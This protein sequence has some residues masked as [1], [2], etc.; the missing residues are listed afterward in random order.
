MSRPACFLL[1]SPQLV[2]IVLTI[3]FGSEAASDVWVLHSLWRLLTREHPGANLFPMSL[4]SSPGKIVAGSDP[5]AMI[6][7]SLLA[8]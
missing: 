7:T 1:H 2:V 3:C 5:D 6:V 8:V 4:T